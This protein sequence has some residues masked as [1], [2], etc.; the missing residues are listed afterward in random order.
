MRF[1]DRFEFGHKPNLQTMM[2]SVYATRF[3]QRHA[4]GLLSEAAAKLF[5]LLFARK[6][7]NRYSDRPSQLSAGQSKT[8][9]WRELDNTTYD[10]C[11][12]LLLLAGWVAGWRA[13]RRSR[14]TRLRLLHQKPGATQPPHSPGVSQERV[15]EDGE[16]HPC[17]S[18]MGMLGAR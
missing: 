4:S 2:D 12:L 3:D 7:F 13:W 11:C 5:G 14:A 18:S 1:G 9:R 6:T 8:P 10:S 15:V 17:A 16:P